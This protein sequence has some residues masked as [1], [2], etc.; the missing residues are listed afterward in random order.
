MR[1]EEGKGESPT[2][3]NNQMN[4]NNNMIM[5]EFNIAEELVIDDL[6]DG[7]FDERE[8]GK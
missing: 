3:K 7:E 1:E 5:D 6:D 4:N 8:L 2:K